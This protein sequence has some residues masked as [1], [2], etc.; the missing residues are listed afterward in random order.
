[1]A[2]NTKPYREAFESAVEELEKAMTRREELDGER[3]RLRRRLDCVTE[4]YVDLHRYTRAVETC[5]YLYSDS[6]VFSVLRH[7]PAFNSSVYP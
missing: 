2:T 5:R 1:M 7:T 4:S 3:E 6:F